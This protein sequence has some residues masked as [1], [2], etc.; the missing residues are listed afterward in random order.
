M[1][2]ALVAAPSLKTSVLPVGVGWGPAT[3]QAEYT[4]LVATGID[5]TTRPAEA[6]LSPYGS[7]AMLATLNLAATNGVKVAVYDGPLWSDHERHD[8]VGHD[9]DDD[10]LQHVLE[11]ERGEVLVDQGRAWKASIREHPGRGDQAEDARRDQAPVRQP[12]PRQRALLD[13]RWYYSWTSGSS[14][15]EST[16]GSSTTDRAEITAVTTAVKAF[17]KYLAPATSEA[18]WHADSGRPPG[19]SARPTGDPVTLD[20]VPMYVGRFTVPAQAGKLILIGNRSFTTRVESLSTTSICPTTTTGHV[21]YKV[22]TSAWTLVSSGAAAGACVGF[23]LSLGAGEAQ[24][25][26]VN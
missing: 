3:T 20:N 16:F 7:A 6:Y 25:F 21:W 19:T 15:T 14:P 1:D 23:D 17:G 5:S 22:G 18:V 11:Q 4:N 12:A 13:A 26:Y 24:L 10:V 8:R 9:G 2:E